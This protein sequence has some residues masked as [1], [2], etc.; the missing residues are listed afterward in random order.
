[1]EDKKSFK[2]MIIFDTALALCLLCVA[3]VLFFVFRSP[4]SRGDYVRI[5]VGGEFVADFPLDKDGEYYLNE[6]TNK[7][8]ISDGEAYIA[9]AD[10]PDKICVHSGKIAFTGE[11]IVCLPNKVLVEIIGK[12]DV[13]FVS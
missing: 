2:K 13:D 8:I 9:E 11:R 3:L 1:M 12:S 5:T 10:C 6:G 4:K 7:L